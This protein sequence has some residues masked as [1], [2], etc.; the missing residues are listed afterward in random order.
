[1]FCNTLNAVSFFIDKYI[2]LLSVIYEPSL[3]LVILNF[4]DT[5]HRSAFPVQKGFLR[6]GRRQS[7]ST[8]FAQQSKNCEISLKY[9]TLVLYN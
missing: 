7:V 6:G 5:E 9:F 4:V 8:A 2:D 1:M 3:P